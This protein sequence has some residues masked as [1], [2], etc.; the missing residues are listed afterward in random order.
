MLQAP[1]AATGRVC[2]GGAMLQAPAAGH[3]LQKR[4]SMLSTL[5]G[6]TVCRPAGQE[7][8][9][10]AAPG[11]LWPAGPLIFLCAALRVAPSAHALV[12]CM[13]GGAAG[14]LRPLQGPLRQRH[15]GCRGP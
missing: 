7:E 12:L 2:A 9:V 15:E 5:S 10:G 13:Q 1:A 3:R 4:P 11:R 6:L 8:A 14:A